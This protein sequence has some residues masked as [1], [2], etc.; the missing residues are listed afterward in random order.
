MHTSTVKGVTFDPAGSYFASSGDDPAVCIWR[1]HDDWG[2]E[3]RLDAD[4]GIFRKWR[5]GD[6]QELSGQTLFRRLSWSTDGAYIC[7]TNASIKN[8]HV[9]STIS[10]EGWSVS[11]SRS[12]ASGAANLVGHKQPV[13]VSRHCPKLLN[14]KP[15][16]EDGSSSNDHN[17]PDYAT[18]IALG[19]KRGFV[20]V[21]STRKSRPLFKL[22]CSENRCTVTDLAWG[23]IGTTI[24]LLVSMLDGH[25]VA[26][27]FG[28]PSEVGMLLSNEDQKRVFELRYG[29]DFDN[30]NGLRRGGMFVGDSKAPRLIE[31]ALQFTMEYKDDEESRGDA[32]SSDE[33]NEENNAGNDSPLSN[34]F[35]P[36]KLAASQIEEKVKGKKRIRP[37]LMTESNERKRSKENGDVDGGKKERKKADVVKDAL[38]SAAKA[39]SAVDDVVTPKV[40]SG[41][42]TPVD[43]LQGRNQHSLNRDQSTSNQQSIAPPIHRQSTPMLLHSVERIHS[44]TLPLLS[45]SLTKV[46]LS[47]QKPVMVL[48]CTNSNRVPNG[49][50]EPPLPCITPFPVLLFRF[51]TEVIKNG[52]T[53]S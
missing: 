12:T 49:S 33:K 17:E 8:K 6:A 43:S 50:S 2:L 23:G 36:S 10:R 41:H 53:T 51:V 44:L 11:S 1:A 20:T 7:S 38:E 48:D 32:T 40:S 16:R 13:V 21:W 39:A 22:Q 4:S 42:S 34:V 9:A 46:M 45:G 29:I 37:V 18:L 19:D 52:R 35:S 15:T 24:V 47:E 14:T 25:V 27:R 5:E 28:V 26:L 3:K 30:D 31:N